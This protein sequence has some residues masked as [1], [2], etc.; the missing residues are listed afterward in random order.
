[1]PYLVKMVPLVNTLW[2]F[3]NYPIIIILLNSIYFFFYSYG[4]FKKIK[5]KYQ[6]GIKSLKHLIDT[7]KEI[8][9]LIGKDSL[10]LMMS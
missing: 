1:M 8:K 6:K 9:H 3:A 7:K 2:Y 5:W 4:F 10:T